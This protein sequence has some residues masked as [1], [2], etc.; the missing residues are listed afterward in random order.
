MPDFC[1]LWPGGPKF[2]QSGHFPLGTDSVLLSDFAG[3]PAFRRGIDLGCG[4]GII[5]LLL[6][7]RFEKLRMTGL[8]ILPEAAGKAVENMALNGLD[9]RG[10]IICGDMRL[11]RERFVS[12]QFDFAVSN[13]PYFPQGSGF[14][15]KGGGRVSARTEESCSLGELCSCAAYLVR[16]G[17]SFFLVHRPERLS[18]VFCRMTECGLEPKRLRFVQHTAVSAPSLV[19]IEGRRGGRPGLRV[20]PALIMRGD[21]G[22]SEEI[23]RIYHLEAEAAE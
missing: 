17:G 19:L 21:S 1:T 7:V 16:T 23:K 4:S 12:G 14:A 20:E 18:E 22:D 8:E 10:E 9:G 11:C 13:P 15:P 5:T 6:L 3:S 2:I